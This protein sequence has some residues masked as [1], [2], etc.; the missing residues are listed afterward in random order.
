MRTSSCL[1]FAASLLIFVACDS[2]M[3]VSP[4]T[5]GVTVIGCEESFRN[6]IDQ[7]VEVFQFTY[8]NAYIHVNYMDEAAEMDSL[9][10]KK[11]NMIITT[12]NLTDEQRKLLVRQGRGARSYRIA[13][14]AVA[15]IANNA[16]DIDELTMQN[17]RDILNGKI[18]QWGEVYPTRF[19]NDTIKLVVDRNGSGVVHYLK[20]KFTQGRNFDPS[21]KVYAMTSSEEVFEAIKKNKHA[22]GFVGVSWITSDMNAT[23]KTI[24][25]RVE[26]LKT[27]NE[28]SVIDFTDK[29][30]VMA[31]KAD[32]QLVARKPYQAY[33]NSG[34]YPLFREIWAIDAASM[35]SLDHGF[36]S[37]ITGVVGQKVILQTGILPAAAPV[38]YVETTK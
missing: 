22:I 4:N 1:L 13:V 12:H 27:K 26:E 31:V 6:I 2:K 36:Y 5:N 35:S 28:V 19:R 14:D 24:E 15:V 11:L 32:D 30:K 33:I 9:L 17:L 16:N 37:F 21:V 23:E 7:E 3:P 8:P 29:I 38:R 25:Q 18:H 10:N 34:E 20:D